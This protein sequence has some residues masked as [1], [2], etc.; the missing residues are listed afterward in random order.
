MNGKKLPS[1]LLILS[2]LLALTALAFCPSMGKADAGTAETPPENSDAEQETAAE[3]CWDAAH[4][5][6]GEGLPRTALKHI[7]PILE[8][9]LE[10][11]NHAEAALAA[12]YKATIEGRIQGYKPEEVIGVLEAK[13]EE[14]PKEMHPVMHA[15]LAHWYW[16][17]FRRNRWR[18][19]RRTETEEQPGEDITTWDLPRLF[20]EID[21][22]YSRVLDEE[23][24]LRRIPIEEYDDLLR[25]GT[26]PDSYRPTLYDFI[27]AEA[28]EFY[29]SGEQ[30]SALPQDPFVLRPDSPV[31]EPLEDFLDWEIETPDPDSPVY[32]AARLY[33]DVLAFHLEEDNED[34]L[35]DWDLHRL[36]FGYNMAA[37]EEKEERYRE[38]LRAFMD[39]Y[40]EHEIAA[41]AGYNLAGEKKKQG[42]LVEAHELASEMIEKYPDS[43]G[44]GR[45]RRLVASIEAPSATA[46]TER[47][48]NEAGPEVRLDYKNI[49]EIHFRIVPWNWDD[50]MGEGTEDH[51]ESDDEERYEQMLD[52]EPVLEW[53]EQ[54]ES[55]DDYQRRSAAFQPPALPEPGSYF[56][57][58]APDPE[59]KGKVGS[60][61]SYTPFWGSDLAL[62]TRFRR[63]SPGIEGLVLDAMSGAP[64]EGADL[65][66]WALAQPR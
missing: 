32:K 5:A 37:G 49:T 19:L 27:A 30:A 53:S 56:L 44:A 66:G 42:E 3:A 2:I 9:A 61:V 55:T 36:R 1:Q 14:M 13:I 11:E 22:N 57:L 38:A 43:R 35:I 29:C 28:L 62:V 58:A 47:V 54:L 59:F 10:E 21:K 40:S 20:A 24:M 7:E 26:M 65:S 41:R 8:N 15:I 63:G 33:Q 25:G 48:W 6:L 50:Y 64:V 46:N 18:F 16:R 39:R 45:C 52:A 31:F 17:Y 23:D 34:A 51:P 60:V 12:G 4:E